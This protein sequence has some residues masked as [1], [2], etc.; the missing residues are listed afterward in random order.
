[1][2]HFNK[3]A[4]QKGF[5]MSNLGQA[6]LITIGLL[7]A[8]LLVVGLAMWGLYRFFSDA[9]EGKTDKGEVGESNLD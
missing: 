5:D 8:S 4:I 7:F 3:K 1:M 2:I 6:V 9:K